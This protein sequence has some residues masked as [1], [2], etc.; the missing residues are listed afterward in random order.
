MVAITGASG[1][2]LGIALLKELSKHNNIHTHLIVSEWA[3]KILESE[4]GISVKELVDLA[5]HHYENGNLMAPVASGTFITNGMVIIP[6]STGTLA[7]IANG[8]AND[9]ITRAA[10][11]TLKEKRKLVLVVRETPLSPIH[12]ENMLRVSRGGAIILPPVLT[13]HQKPETIDD[14][15][16]FV[17]GKTLDVFQIEHHLFRRWSESKSDGSS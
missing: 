1:V 3:T 7:A 2:R 13:F 17:V 4:E 9:L 11:V 6:C 10:S 16:R 15:V 12:I 8:I 14:L 5:E